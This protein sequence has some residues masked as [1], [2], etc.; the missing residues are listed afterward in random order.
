MSSEMWVSMAGSGNWGRWF[1]DDAAQDQY[2]SLYRGDTKYG[3]L[4]ESQRDLV[5]LWAGAGIYSDAGPDGVPLM[6]VMVEQDM[7]VFRGWFKEA[8]TAAAQVV[9]DHLDSYKVLVAE[10][11]DGRV[12]ES[13]L[14]T[15][16][17][18]G[19]TVDVGTLEVLE[20]GIMGRPPQRKDTG[21]YFLWGQTLPSSDRRDYGVNSFGTAHFQSCFLWS[22]QTERRA[23]GGKSVAIPVFDAAMTAKVNS[24]CL[25]ISRDLA[26][27]FTANYAAISTLSR[28]CSFSQAS[29]GDTLCMVFHIGYEFIIDELVD[30]G[31][32]EPFPGVAGPDWGFW[33]EWQ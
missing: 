26:E 10:M 25:P 18:C 9:V 29:E 13:N 33:V 30:L 14:L 23:Q 3:D 6:P 12:N 22:S 32:L 15:I 11:S 1:P 27:A 4:N 17:I 19:R 21:A 31:V 2:L 28:T 16:L 8:A 20:G 24:L 5:A 7:E